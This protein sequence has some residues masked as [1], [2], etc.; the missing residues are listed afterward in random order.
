MFDDPSLCP[1][2]F[3]LW[4]HHVPWSYTLRNGNDL[5]TELCYKYSSGVDAVR[6]FQKVWD[7]NH[8][9]IDQQRF[10]DVK[11]KLVTQTKEAIWWR[12][13]C[14]LYFQTFSHL[15]IP[16][17]LDRPIHQLDQLKKLKFDLKN[18]N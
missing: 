2:A 12:D 11:K 1:E 8:E 17:N 14:L 4:F 3:L 6:R 9:N 13:A 7:D 10:E 18:H 15:P 5:W 16:L